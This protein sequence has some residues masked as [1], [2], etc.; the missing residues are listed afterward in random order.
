[1]GDFILP[2]IRPRN[3]SGERKIT[4]LRGALPLQD[5]RASVHDSAY[6]R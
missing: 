6:V 5:R 4:R 3:R 2:I 1:M